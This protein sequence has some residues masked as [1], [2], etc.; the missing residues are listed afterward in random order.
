MQQKKAKTGKR[1][2]SAGKKRALGGKV[3][4]RPVVNEKKPTLRYRNRVPADDAYIL[5]LTEGQLAPV[6]EQAF[7]EPF[8]REQFMSVI[9]SGAPVIMIEYGGKPIGYY[10][11]LVGQDSRMHIN[12]MVI[13]K[14]YQ[15]KGIGTQVMKQVE[16]DAR[17][18]GVRVIEVYVQA[19]NEQSLAFT[20]QLGFVEA[21]RVPPNTICF[22]KQ[23][24]AP[25]TVPAGRPLY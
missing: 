12:A 10:T 6:H 11:Y 1:V 18:R 9:Q 8:P 16:E 4:Q 14:S 17:G 13:D 2:G 7:G 3:K 24:S 22:Q 15:S 23:L 5:Q 20:R 25:N 19:N 21:Y